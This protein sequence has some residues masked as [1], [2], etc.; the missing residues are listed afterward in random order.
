MKTITSFDYRLYK[1][2]NPKNVEVHEGFT[3]YH[4]KDIIRFI[5]KTHLIELNTEGVK[6]H[7][8]VD[9][10]DFSKDTMWKITS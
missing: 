10:D 9:R 2:P 1:L 6:L 7:K 3:L 4:D 8:N 5:N